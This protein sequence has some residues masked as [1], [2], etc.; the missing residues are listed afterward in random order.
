MRPTH[1][2]YAL[3]F[4]ALMSAFM[5]VVMTGMLTALNTGIDAGLPWRW[6]KASCLAWPIAFPLVLLIG[7]RIHRILAK[8]PPY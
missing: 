5:V 2:Y 3:A 8:L 4:S 7:P 1:R 6:F